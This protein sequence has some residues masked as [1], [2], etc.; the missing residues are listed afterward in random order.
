MPSFVKVLTPSI[1]SLDQTFNQDFVLGWLIKKFSNGL[2]SIS[3][4]LLRLLLLE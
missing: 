3:F 2:S 4:S 1:L